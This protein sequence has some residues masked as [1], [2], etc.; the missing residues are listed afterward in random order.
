MD[1]IRAAAEWWADQLLNY[2]ERLQYFEGTKSLLSRCINED[3]IQV[4]LDDLEE[5][6]TLELKL[7]R[8]DIELCVDHRAEGLLEE[9]L[10][11]ARIA[12]LS[13]LPSKTSMWLR[14]DFQGKIVKIEVKEGYGEP[15]K[16]LWANF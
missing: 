6:I 3:S 11:E 9:S 13:S 12:N 2:E 7:S 10:K 5:K 4:F 16:T 1:P 14:R 15:P 8:R